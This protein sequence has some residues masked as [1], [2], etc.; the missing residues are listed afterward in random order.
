MARQGL[1]ER[2]KAA[3]EKRILHAAVEAFRKEDY[4]SVRIEDLAERAEVAV[5]TVYNYYRTKGDILVATVA[6]EVEEVLAGGE[7]M[8]ADPPPGAEAALMQLIFSYYD[9]SLEYLSKDMW[10]KAM[11][12]AIEA[13]ETP[14]GQ[15]YSELDA[16]LAAQITALI[17]LLQARGEVADKW[18]AEPLGQLIFNNLNMQFIEFV[19]DE[20]M[21]LAALRAR[22]AAQ[23]APLLEMIRG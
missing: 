18:Q 22:V 10:R 5:G 16:R 21:T 13:P 23:M 12:L 2:Q 7:A 6:M 1:R 14:N 19:K 4:R 15:R 3:R 8:L 9:H 17:R 20:G 11:A